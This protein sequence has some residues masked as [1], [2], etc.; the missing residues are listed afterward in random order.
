MNVLGGLIAW[1]SD[2]ANWR[3]VDGVP[4]RVLQHLGYSSAAIAIAVAVAL[5]IG[6]YIGHT[7]RGGQVAINVA[8]LGRAI[9]SLAIIILAFF[10]AGISVVTVLVALA[11]LA[12]PPIVTNTYVGIRSVD[13]EVRESAEGMGMTGAEVL[14]QVEVPVALQI[15]MAGIRTS[16][17]QVVATATLAAFIGL[18]GL[19]RYIIDGLTQRNTPEV[20]A[21]ALLVALLS[22][23][24][25]Y[26]LAALQ[27]ALVS[28]GIAA[29]AT[30]HPALEE[31]A[32][33]GRVYAG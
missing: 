20:V 6:L 13:P 31:P 5:P 32:Q 26:G 2:A 28:P 14:R 29:T 1:F 22:I 12:L 3:G 23:L 19:G 17:V 7:G 24:T 15:V 16:A 4:W 18:G 30:T 25:E 9:P 33:A 11:A 21:G 10:V 27:R 8:N